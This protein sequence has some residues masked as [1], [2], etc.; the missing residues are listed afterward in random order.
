M[1]NDKWNDNVGKMHLDEMGKDEIS[2]ILNIVHLNVHYS[3]FI[4]DTWKH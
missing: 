1:I 2:V 4:R 3:A